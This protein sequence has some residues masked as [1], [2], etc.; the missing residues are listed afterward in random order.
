MWKMSHNLS[1]VP[2][3]GPPQHGGK[4]P[5]EQRVNEWIKDIRA[6]QRASRESVILRLIR[7][8][9]AQEEIAEVIELS[10]NRI[11]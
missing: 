9:W 11:S 5:T 10:Q 4:C 3:T 1:P 7:L 8:G 6:R 2:A